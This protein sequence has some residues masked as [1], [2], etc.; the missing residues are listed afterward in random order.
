MHF[1][2]AFELHP[3]LFLAAAAAAEG[4]Q[5]SN[6]ARLMVFD[7]SFLHL[8]YPGTRAIHQGLGPCTCRPWCN[9]AT[10]Y[11]C[12][13]EAMQLYMY[14]VSYGEPWEIPPPPPKKKNLGNNIN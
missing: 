1:N 3:G 6:K 14:R 9:Y 7:L 2:V 10:E 8:F 13:Y 4:V 11:S 5:Q 12:R